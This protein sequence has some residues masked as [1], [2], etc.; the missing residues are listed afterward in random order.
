MFNDLGGGSAACHLESAGIL[1]AAERVREDIAIGCDLVVLNECCK[2]EADGGGLRDAFAHTGAGK[3]LSF[4]AAGPVNGR[5]W[6]LPGMQ[7]RDF[8]LLKTPKTATVVS[9]PLAIW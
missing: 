5:R 4:S 8:P 3:A 9:T 6:R 2:V 7:T 1:A